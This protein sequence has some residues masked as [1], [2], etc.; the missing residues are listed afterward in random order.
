[1]KNITFVLATVYS[2]LSMTTSTL[3]QAKSVSTER[4]GSEATQAVKDDTWQCTDKPLPPDFEIIREIDEAS[5]HTGRANVIRRSSGATPST[6]TV[7]PDKPPAVAA[8]P[9]GKRDE[10]YGSAKPVEIID[11]AADQKSYV[12]K[13]LKITGQLSVSSYYDHGYRKAQS[14]HLAFTL[15][16]STGSAYVYVRRE[17]FGESVREQILQAKNNPVH[18]TFVIRLNPD[19]Y[20][21]TSD[22]FAD[23]IL[24]EPVEK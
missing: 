5:C 15:K 22:V 7:Q 17:G 3:A 24:V 10:I 12:S 14:T 4:P 19:R 6:P 2:L 20:E 18:G 11:V 16:D 8:D 21:T 9:S 13:Y 1:M 23:L